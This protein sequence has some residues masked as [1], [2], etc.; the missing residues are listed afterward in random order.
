MIYSFSNHPN[1]VF[2]SYDDVFFRQVTVFL[3]KV[4]GSFR[5]CKGCKRWKSAKP[6]FMISATS[7]NTTTITTSTTKN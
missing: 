3:K 4:C 6:P 5:S 1:G 2:A 7:Y